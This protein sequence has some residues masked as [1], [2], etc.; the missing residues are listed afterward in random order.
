MEQVFKAITLVTGPFTLVAFI[1]A[2]YAY[3]SSRSSVTPPSLRSLAVGDESRTEMLK[4]LG[5]THRLEALKEILKIDDKLVEKVKSEWDAG[6]A[7]KQGLRARSLN[8]GITAILGLGLFV[9]AALAWQGSGEHTNSE[10]NNVRV[11]H[12]TDEGRDIN[13]D[14]A[15]QLKVTGARLECRSGNSF[16]LTFSSA[17][18]AAKIRIRHPTEPSKYLCG[19]VSLGTTHTL[20]LGQDVME[21]CQ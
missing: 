16:V 17:N 21:G 15:E 12:V 4:V 8:A 5:E 19:E 14:G 13:I 2:V 20:R 11:F 3:Y 9:V 10:R 18:E 1:Y 6:T 7:A